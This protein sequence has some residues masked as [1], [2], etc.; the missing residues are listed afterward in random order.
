MLERGAPAR[1]P[2]CPARPLAHH[3]VPLRHP[4]PRLAPG[5]G[6]LVDASPRLPLPPMRYATVPP[7]RRAT[8]RI[9]EVVAAPRFDGAGPADSRLEGVPR[10]EPSPR[11]PPIGYRQAARGVSPPTFEVRVAE[12]GS[13]CVSPPRPASIAEDDAPRP[14][15]ALAEPETPS[16]VETERAPSEAETRVSRRASSASRAA[17]ARPLERKVLNTERFNNGARASLARRV[18]AVGRSALGRQRATVR[19][20]LACSGLFYALSLITFYFLSLP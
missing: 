2:P 13:R 9:F 14:Q 6:V 11:R 1:L 12:R 18:R 19:V 5:A 20:L 10:R 7:P 3:H 15:F 4:V 16:E 17:A 8:P